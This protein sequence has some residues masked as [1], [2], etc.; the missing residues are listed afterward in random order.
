MHCLLMGCPAVVISHSLE[1]VLKFCPGCGPS[2]FDSFIT[3]VQVP[4]FAPSPC[5]IK[6][7]YD[8][9]LCLELP[10]CVFQ[11][12]SSCF[13]VSC[14]LQ[15]TTELFVKI[16]SLLFNHC[17]DTLQ[18]SVSCVCYCFFELTVASL[19]VLILLFTSFWQAS[20][21]SW[22]VL[23]SFY[24]LL[25]WCLT[26]VTVLESIFDPTSDNQL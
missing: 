20:S 17:R 3:M 23:M 7:F 12:M 4:P 1:L 18:L 16:L 19:M 22:P 21:W 8:H 14:H 26:Y 2:N 15:L 11:I 5:L 9:Q 25:G 13:S 6:S 24:V 10:L